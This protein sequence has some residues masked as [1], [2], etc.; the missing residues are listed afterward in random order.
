VRYLLAGPD[1]EKPAGARDYVLMLVMLLLSLRVSKVCY[2]A[3]RR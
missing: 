1:R 3:P 2:F